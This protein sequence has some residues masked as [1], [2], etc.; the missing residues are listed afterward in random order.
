[1]LCDIT[2]EEAREQLGQVADEVHVGFDG[3]WT[4][5][6]AWAWPSASSGS[7]QAA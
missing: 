2:L 6:G 7:P 5:N 3:F 4:L 1:M